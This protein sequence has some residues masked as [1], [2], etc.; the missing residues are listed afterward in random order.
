MRIVP[1]TTQSVTSLLLLSTCSNMRY[2]ICPNL[3]LTLHF[4]YG[5]NCDTCYSYSR[6]YACVFLIGWPILHVYANG[7]LCDQFGSL[8]SEHPGRMTLGI[9]F[10]CTASLTLYTLDLQKLH[11]HFL[12]NT[13]A[14]SRQVSFQRKGSELDA[15]SRH[16]GRKCPA[17]QHAGGY[18]GADSSKGPR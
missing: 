3:L 2:F 15:C 18:C 16:A 1:P 5:V 8:I 7:K 9:S 6:T 12:Q 17:R 10:A 14:R 11:S 4:V 13:S